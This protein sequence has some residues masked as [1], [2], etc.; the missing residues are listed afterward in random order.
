MAT[1]FAFAARNVPSERRR[2]A[3]LDG[4]H[5]LQL[6][7]AHVAAIGLTPS[8]A[9]VA[10]DIRNLQSWTGHEGRRL[11]GRLVLLVLLGQLIERAHHLGDQVGGDTCVV[12]RRI[13]PLVAEQSL[14]HPD[15]ELAL[16]QV[17]RKTMAQGMQRC[18]LSDLGCLSGEM[19]DAI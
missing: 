5:H 12:R 17:G 1:C 15:I 2:A 14:D 3:A 9:V 13:E 10:E 11:L 7:E 8:G 18:T 6:P 16:Q 19:K 4:R